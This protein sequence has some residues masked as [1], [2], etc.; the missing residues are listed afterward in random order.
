MILNKNVFSVDGDTHLLFLTFHNCLIVNNSSYRG[1]TG[2]DIASNY[3]EIPKKINLNIIPSDE[4][5][6][7][8]R[9]TKLGGQFTLHSG[10]ICAF[11]RSGEDACKGDGGAPLVCTIPG[12]PMRLYQAG[13]V[14]W[15][16]INQ[17]YFKI[18]YKY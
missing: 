13:I 2:L 8:L 14:S 10:F 1:K 11:G 17:M 5:Q 16:K 6:T 12:N 18:M 9:R 7:K 15:G 4:C 3:S